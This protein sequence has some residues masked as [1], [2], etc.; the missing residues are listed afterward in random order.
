MDTLKDYIFSGPFLGTFIATMIFLFSFTYAGTEAT[1]TKEERINN[2]A[3]FAK[4]ILSTA[5]VL[6]IFATIGVFIAAKSFN[7]SPKSLTML[8]FSQMLYLSISAIV[9]TFVIT[10]VSY[11]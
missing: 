8:I 9:F 3:K 11:G 2:P 5:F 7:E 10:N 6:C 1:I 4:V